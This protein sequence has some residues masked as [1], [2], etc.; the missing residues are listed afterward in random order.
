M[1]TTNH[2]PVLKAPPHSVELEQAVLSA[3]LSDPRAMDVV[4]DLISASD[5]Y[6]PNN[7]LIYETSQNLFASGSAVDAITVA[8]RLE[9][10][11]D[12][13]NAGGV[14]YLA[15]LGAGGRGLANL[16]YYASQVRDKALE[17]KLI[18]EANRIADLGYNSSEGA[19]AKIE[20]AQAAFLAIGTKRDKT[21]L[22]G[23]N[24]LLREALDEIDYRSGLGSG[25]VGMSTGFADLDK[26]TGG[27]E[28]GTMVVIAGRP[29]MGKSTIAMN[30]AEHAI[31]ND[32]RVCVFN[33]EMPRKSLMLRTYSS[34]SGV[35]H[36]QLRKGRLNDDDWPKVNATVAKLKGKPLQIDDT[37]AL[38]TS[39]LRARLRRAQHS[40]ST[41]LIVL[42]Y[43][44]IMG[45]SNRNGDVSRVTEISRNL[46]AIG[47]EFECPIIVLSQLSRKVEERA[48]KRPMMSDLRESGAIEQ[49]ADLILMMYRDEY[50]NAESQFKG[51][52]EVIIGKQRNGPTG[53]IHLKS[54]LARMRFV[55]FE[56]EVPRYARP[57]K[58]F[59]KTLGDVA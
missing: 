11:G 45:D 15:E 21:A 36:E 7:R 43:L 13:E 40:G 32:K 38:T 31:L 48:N 12:I 16:E 30:I 53:T 27:L 6:A 35:F 54:D 59:A 23:M 50:Y 22:V 42:D 18:L 29:S 4:T 56:G 52:A 28:A 47:K 58:P 51:I 14:D 2:N 19:S 10:S 46:K 26:Q 24:Q 57:A 41:D 55:D 33:L 20:Q 8:D 34:V 37:P 25:L 3:V 1:E 5:F 9:N 44:Q 17:R 49:D 39:Q